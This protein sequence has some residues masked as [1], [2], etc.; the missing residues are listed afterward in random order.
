MWG[1]GDLEDLSPHCT[2]QQ[3]GFG[4]DDQQLNS[5]EAPFFFPARREEVQ[6]AL[7]ASQGLE[8]IPSL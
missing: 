5:F 6:H 3:S 1:G 4:A 2:C 7:T 8:I